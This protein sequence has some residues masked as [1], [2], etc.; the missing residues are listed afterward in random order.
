[1]LCRALKPEASTGAEALGSTWQDGGQEYDIRP[2]GEGVT[3][4]AD[5]DGK[6]WGH[7]K[8]GPGTS[9]DDTGKG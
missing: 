3:E 4:S 8:T 6:I 2:Q 7:L 5:S 9:K 1:M